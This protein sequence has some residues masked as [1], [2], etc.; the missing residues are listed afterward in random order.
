MVAGKYVSPAKTPGEGEEAKKRIDEVLMGDA[1]RIGHA[2]GEARGL[3]TST[4]LLTDVYFLYTPPQIAFAAFLEADEALARAYLDVKFPATLEESEKTKEKLL[5]IISECAKNHL[6]PGITR[7]SPNPYP[8][9]L[10]QLPQNGIATSIA[11]SL[12]RALM[13]EVTR[14]DKKLYHVTN[15]DKKASEKKA[16]NGEGNY[17]GEEE[18]K[19]LKKRRLERERLDRDGDVFGGP[20]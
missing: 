14:I 16:V 19:R 3:L 12:E 15:R 17:G 7:D 1:G 5:R 6:S 8:G 2:H 9:L 20:L 10:L 18:D 11:A 13:K 4:A